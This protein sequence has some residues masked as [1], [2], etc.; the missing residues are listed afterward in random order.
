MIQFLQE[1]EDHQ[2][3]FQTKFPHGIIAIFFGHKFH[4]ALLHI[5]FGFL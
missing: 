2:S 4:L 3:L 1:I 5:V